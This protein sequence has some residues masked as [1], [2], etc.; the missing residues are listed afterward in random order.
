MQE[1]RQPVEEERPTGGWRDTLR[2]CRRFAWHL[3]AVYGLCHIIYANTLDVARIT[4]PSMAPA[5][6]GTDWEHGDTVLFEKVSYRFRKPR[7]W[8]VVS[9]REPSGDVLVKRI[10]GLP[11]DTI[12]LPRRGVIVINGQEVS[13]PAELS[14]LNPLPY[15]NVMSGKTFDCG[16][17][18]YVLGDNSHDSD[19]SRFNGAVDPDGILSRAWY[20]VSPRERFGRINPT[21]K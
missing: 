13:P 4:S 15:G 12:Q 2:V 19:D 17:G 3:L 14:Y 21:A 7:R 1:Q 9:F 8:E 16:N 20:I 18:Y 10:V 11:G 6:D 5:L